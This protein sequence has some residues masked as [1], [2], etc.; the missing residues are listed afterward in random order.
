MSTPMT[1]R[2]VASAAKSSRFAYA[3]TRSTAPSFTTRATQ[4][5]FHTSR[6]AT[7]T[8]TT[9]SPCRPTPPGYTT[10]ALPFRGRGPSRGAIR[11]LPR[12]PVRIDEDRTTFEGGGTSVAELSGPG[13]PRW[14]GKPRVVASPSDRPNSVVVQQTITHR[15]TDI[16]PGRTIEAWRRTRCRLRSGWRPSERSS[17]RHT[18]TA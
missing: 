12:C 5:P 15:L 14:W 13:A 16:P 18:P 2:S 10:S 6:P 1:A 11:M 9:L 8:P 17:I 3:A 4:P 7:K